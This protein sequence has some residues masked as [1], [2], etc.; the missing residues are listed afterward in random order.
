MESYD[1]VRE[2]A[3]LIHAGG[4]CAVIHSDDDIDIQRL[5]QEAAKTW[6][7][8]QRLGLDIPKEEAMTWLFLNPARALG[9]DDE[10]GSLEPGKRGDVVIWNRDP[11]SVYAKAEQVFLDGVLMYDRTDPAVSPRT[12]FEVGQLSH[13][14]SGGAGQ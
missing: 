1:G 9:I 8:G 4:A 2:N 7:D 13:A 10:V 5:N 11:F 3:S 12:D 14:R 6:A